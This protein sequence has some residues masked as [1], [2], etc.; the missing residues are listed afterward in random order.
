[1]ESRDLASRACRDAFGKP[2]LQAVAKL[3]QAEVG[4]VLDTTSA[5]AS[6]EWMPVAAAT[7]RA[8]H[9]RTI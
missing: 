8:R 2:V 4:Q 5:Q 3:R 9:A 7:I 6:I 1:M